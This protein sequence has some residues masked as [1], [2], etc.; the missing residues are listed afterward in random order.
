MTYEKAN[1]DD[2]K[3]FFK[4]YNNLFSNGKHTVC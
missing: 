2:I 4:L 3:D 1:L